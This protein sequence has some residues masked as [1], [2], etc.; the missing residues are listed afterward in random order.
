MGEVTRPLAV[1]LT[2]VFVVGCTAVP[3]TAAPTAQRPPTGAGA[4][5]SQPSTNS[6]SATT[7]TGRP[8]LAQLIGQKLVIRME[9][10]T[11]SADLLGRIRRGEVGGVILFGANITTK[12][13]LITLTRSLRA[14]ARAGGQPTLL[15]AVDQE[16]GTIKRIP[17][18]PPTLSP[19]E[20][21]KIGKTSV[22]RGQ[23]SSTG[24]ALHGLGINVDFA[25]VADVPNSTSS[26][27]YR[28]GR[29]FS[30]SSTTT[31]AL[32]DAFASGLMSTGVLPSMKHFPGLGRATANTDRY[33][34]T[35]K[36]S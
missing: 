9:G 22:A 8:T 7:L 4:A 29:T 5:P 13:A 2:A 36:A 25:P 23:G 31:A 10:K 27:M 33:V 6:G 19:P 20:M 15:I 21:G 26:F 28:Q 18:A 14:A 34:V 16:G 1:L 11:P 32:S 24:T 35:I 17:W 12:A 3:P 30:F